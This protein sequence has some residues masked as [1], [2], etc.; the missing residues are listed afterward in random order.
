MKCV[1]F[2]FTDEDQPDF[3]KDRFIGKNIR[4]IDATLTFP[5]LLLFLDFEK[6]FDTSE[7]SF[8]QKAVDTSI[9]ARP[10]STGLKFL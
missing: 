7:R 4:L 10:R 9:L 3:L 8:I 2:K 1:R 6:A 5:G